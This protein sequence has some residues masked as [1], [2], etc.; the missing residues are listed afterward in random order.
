M[1]TFLNFGCKE[2]YKEKPF[3]LINKRKL[4]FPQFLID[5]RLKA[6]YLHKVGTKAALGCFGENLGRRSRNIP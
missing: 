4:V 3:Q 5:L 2:E 6:S 1:Q